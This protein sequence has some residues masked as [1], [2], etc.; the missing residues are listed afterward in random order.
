MNIIGRK[1]ARLVL[2]GVPRADLLPPEVGL[3]AKA[4]SLRRGLSMLVVAAMVVVGVGYGLATLRASQ[5]QQQLDAENAR[6][7]S[8]LAEQAKYVEVRSV[9]N[10]LK[11]TTAARQVGASTEINWQAYLQ[12][13]QASLPAG[14][15]ITTFKA[16]S[17]SPLVAFAPPTVPLQGERIAE[18]AFSATSPSLPDVQAWLDALTTLKGFVDASPGTVTLASGGVYQVTITMHINEGALANRYADDAVK[19]GGK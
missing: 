10:R 16:T 7:A 5:T 1:D 2:G 6:T 9:N 14:T 12:S 18:L 8:L 13:I 19:D 11:V 3:A 4:R 17:G 15:S